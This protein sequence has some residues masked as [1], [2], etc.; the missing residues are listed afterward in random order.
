MNRTAIRQPNT[1]PVGWR[2]VWDN[3]AIRTLSVDIQIVLKSFLKNGIGKEECPIKTCPNVNLS[4]VVTNSL[5]KS[6]CEHCIYDSDVCY[7]EALIP[8]YD[9]H[10]TAEEALMTIQ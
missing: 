9:K 4:F 8:L 2:R 5:H 1:P 3:N 7:P 6:R 10:I